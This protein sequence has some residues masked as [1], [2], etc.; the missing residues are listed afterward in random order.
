M[1]RIKILILVLFVVVVGSVLLLNDDLFEV[2]SNGDID[3]IKSLLSGNLLYLYLFMLVIMIIQN[4]LTIIPLLIVITINI[5]IFGFVRGFLWSWFTS[6][7]AATIIFFA[8]RYLFQDWLMKKMK[9]ELVAKVESKGFS[10]VLQARIFPFVPTSLVNILAGVSSLSYYKFLL[11]TLIGNFGYFFILALI[12]AGLINFNVD[13]HLVW[14]LIISGFLI[15]Y[16]CKWFL[17][18]RN[19]NGEKKR[20]KSS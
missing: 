13:E 8:V 14:G 3:E 10:Y 11:G 15:Y 9:K 12:P 18:K 17:K 5:S 19:K 16:L 20:I 2:I 7:L 6:A 4:T 1:G